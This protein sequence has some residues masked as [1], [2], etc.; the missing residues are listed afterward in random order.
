MSFTSFP[1]VIH[2]YIPSES[3]E[4]EL[5]A[6]D[7]IYINAEALTATPDGWVEGVS[8][9]TGLSG[10]LPESYTRRTAESDAWTLH[11]KVSLS[12]TETDRNSLR[13]MSREAKHPNVE[14]EPQLPRYDAHDFLGEYS[15]VHNVKSD[16][17]SSRNQDLLEFQ[18]ALSYFS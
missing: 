10:L 4:L 6:G 13:R 17:V 14:K 12:R 11:R 9:L 5:R 18:W 16:K 8:W 1:Q 7:Y 3:D 15:D 2:P